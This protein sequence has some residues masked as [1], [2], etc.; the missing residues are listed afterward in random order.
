MTV[1]RV[2]AALADWPEDD[3]LLLGIPESTSVEFK[4]T[5]YRLT[6]DHQRLE[7]AKDLAAMGNGR[8]GL[9]VLGVETER[10]AGSGL[11]VST[12]VRPINTDRIDIDQMH[13]VARQWIYPPMRE[14]DIRLRRGTDGDALVSI[15]IEASDDPN[16][17]YLIRGAETD[18][19]VNKRLIGA[20]IR[21]Q[22]GVDYFTVEE[23]SEW[24]RRGRGLA[25]TPRPPAEMGE[26]AAEPDRELDAVRER[27]ET[28][29][30]PIFVFQAWP[31]VGAVVEGLHDADGVRGYVTGHEPLR[32][33][34]GFNLQF[35]VAAE[36]HGRGGMAV[37][38]GE[39]EG[40]QITDRGASTFYGTAGPD[41]LGWGMER[42]N[43][44]SPVINPIALAE[45]TYEFSRLF[46]EGVFPH[47]SRPAHPVVMRL[48]VLW[49][50]RPRPIALPVGPRAIGGYREWRRY[51]SDGD[52][53]A[54]IRLD[55][56]PDA[57]VAAGALLRSLYA[58][59]GY[60]REDVPSLSAD[61][62]FD[63]EAFVQAAQ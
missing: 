39:R 30:W 55:V 33:H 24:I 54:S 63:E 15:W 26:D 3:A 57:R 6:S 9:I 47:V 35:G 37:R 17:L 56:D 4:R 36:V 44:Q 8:G 10:D 51:E 18:G 58:Q 46:V 60:G 53:E 52:I 20:P 1:P 5:A 27:Y 29:E 11:D 34:G 12:A 13:Q 43:Q 38:V 14:L 62:A 28:H 49:P 59:F 25:L 40:I 2:F 61:G 16:L 23:V 45:L 32:P 42:H 41:F 21:T 7:F 50:T 48:L 31:R 22:T 19:R